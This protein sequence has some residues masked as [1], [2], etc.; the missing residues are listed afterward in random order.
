[1]VLNY[2]FA[3]RAK[4]MGMLR[5][6]LRLVQCEHCGL[7]FNSTL[8]P[9]LIPYD[10]NYEN[11]Q[12]FSQVFQE[13]LVSVADQLIGRY[14]LTGGRILEV[15]CGKGDFLRLLCK[16]AGADGVGYDT[17]YEG[18]ATTMGRRV[19]FHDRYVKARDIRSPFD[20]VICRHVIEHVGN[21]RPFLAEL[22]ALTAAAGDPVV[23]LE[24][25]AIEWVSESRCFW[26][27]FYEHCNYMS[28][29]CLAYL[30][31]QAGFCVV[32]HKTVFGGQYQL[33]EMK[34]CAAEIPVVHTA[35]AIPVRLGVFARQSEAGVQMMINKLRRHG[36]EK[37]W[38]IWGAGAKGV[39]LVNWL[40]SQPPR[41]V[42][43]SNPAKQ[44]GFIPGSRVP[45]IVPDDP[46]ILKLALVLIANPNYTAEI[47]STLRQAGFSNRI[48]TT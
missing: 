3:T 5:R 16:R 39:A 22:R 15:G 24:T 14:Q 28:Q 26:D 38:A 8:E 12:C 36:S 47:T 25:P 35:P 32:R 27:I 21:L 4:A 37:G 33:L 23:V 45:I 20:A 34:A 10:K 19:R 31:E 13:H 6:D 18:P 30:C 29:P 46:R 41:F 9:D 7:I 1:V 2:R 11:R 40:R 44:G 42:V 43:D 48:L 17:S